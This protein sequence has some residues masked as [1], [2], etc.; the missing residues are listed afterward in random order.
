M[1]TNLFFRTSLF[2]CAAV[3]LGNSLHAQKNEYETR[4]IQLREKINAPANGYFSKDGVP[5]HSSESLICEAP[6]QGH[7]GTSEAYSYWI[8]LEAMYGKIKGDWAPLNSAWTKMERFAIPTN[9]QQPT[10]AD[11]NPNR[12]ATY[13]GE[14]DLPSGY[15]APLGTSVPVGRDPLSPELKATYGNNNIYGMHWLFD[16]DNFYGFGNKGDGISTPSYINTFQRGAQESVW[17]TVPHPSWDDFKWGSTDKSGFLK[18]FTA[19]AGTPAKQWRYTNAP[20]ADARAVQAIY[21]ATQWA[22]EQGLNPATAVPATQAKKMGDYLRLAMFDKY[23]KPMGVQNVNGAGA[24]DYS[25]AHYLMSWYYAWGGP[26]TPAGWSWRIGSSHNHFGYQ[27][28]VAAYALSNVPELIPQS[29]NA[30]RDWGISLVRQLEFYQWLQ[31]ADGAIAGGATNSWNGRY[32]P[33]PAGTP[34]FYGMAYVENPV[35][36][37]PGSNTWFGFQAWSMERVAEIYYLTNNARA[38]AILDKWI[39]WVKSVVKLTPDGDYE[40]P[41]EIGWSGKPNNWNPA[42]PT[43]NTGLRVNVVANNKDVGVAACLAKALIYYAA[44]T[45]RHATLDDA[46]RLLAKELLD[47]MWTKYYEPTGKGLGV[48]EKRA[49]FKRFFE[50]EV[51]VPAGW[52]GVTPK[53]DTIKPGVKFID[54]RSQYRNDPEW[55]RLEA[56][57]RAGTDYVQTY[58]RFWAQVDVALANAEYSNFFGGGTPPPANIPPTVSI[59]APANGA[60]FTAPASINITANAAD[61]DGSVTNVQFF[62]G[63]TS[64]GTDNTA[65]YS[66]SWT[67]VAAGTYSITAK[68][69][70]NRGAT[71]TSA[72]V[73]VTVTGT[74]PPPPPGGGDIEGPACG[75]RNQTLTFELSAANRVN[76][77]SYNWW[78]NGASASITPVAG[79]RYKVNIAT[80]PYFGAGQVCVGVNLNGAPYYRSFC[81][82]VTVCSGGRIGDV[83][84][85]QVLPNPTTNT[86]QVLTT[87]AVASYSVVNFQGAVVLRSGAV[88]NSRSITMGTELGKG[89]YLLLLNYQ[90]GKTETKLIQKF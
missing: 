56:A 35:Y 28:P 27:N 43:A 88:R 24:T 61:A 8:W 78:Y 90:S 21:W 67:G 44:G 45:Q 6:D 39:S 69:T 19:D 82:P 64:L 59:T 25:S 23:F 84:S 16:M 49:D 18:L 85:V 17:E 36:L 11:Y 86:F 34:T 47:R 70:D 60:S 5:Y 55:P 4:F 63:T 13:A 1:T 48:P 2:I 75:S 53:G 87:E 12:P 46:S 50:Q 42:A 81:K 14:F 77:S 73:S 52:K 41:V 3:F 32:E 7:E 68:A 71:T 51:Y 65:P 74:T 89:S 37:D 62:N 66:F 20:D 10:T 26:V 72:A 33:Y 79:M 29:P 80:G 22:K 83:V 15:P 76:A 31:S 38:K 58:H 9:D 40:I 54:I 30:K 57:F